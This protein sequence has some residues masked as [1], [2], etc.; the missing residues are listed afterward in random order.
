MES[1]PD[2]AVVPDNELEEPT[3]TL[4]GDSVD[5]TKI[6][7]TAETTPQD[8]LTIDQQRKLNPIQAYLYLY[9]ESK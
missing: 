3:L 6:N 7:D 8:S 2:T 5:S 4:E 1:E 9:L